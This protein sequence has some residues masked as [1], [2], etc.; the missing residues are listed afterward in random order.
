[1]QAIANG[2]LPEPTKPAHPGVQ[3]SD[4]DAKFNDEV[5]RKILL[6]LRNHHFMTSAAA[7]AGVNAKTVYGWLQRGAKEDAAGME[8]EYTQFSQDVEFAIATSEGKALKTVTDSAQRGDT[9]DAKWILE[10]RHADR[11]AKKDKVEV[12]GDPS[13]PIVV[14]LTW[15][16]AGVVDA[17]SE[18]AL[19]AAQPIIDA[20]VV[21]D[22]DDK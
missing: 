18:I 12:G 7:L 6:A 4:H 19:P 10:R 21:D 16:G 13:Q 22:G 3:N 20:E 2:T 14:Q 9:T 5:R 8:T 11:W 15:P 17:A 1:M